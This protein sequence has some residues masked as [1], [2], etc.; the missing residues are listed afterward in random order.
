M[1]NNGLPLEIWR[2]IFQDATS[3]DYSP[4]NDEE[5]R[6]CLR[7]PGALYAD[8]ATLHAYKVKRLGTV[9]SLSLVCRYFNEIAL[10]FFF[11][12]VF[13]S[14]QNTTC[15]FLQLITQ[16]RKRCD[17][18][19]Q[20]ILNVGSNS[21]DHAEQHF[22]DALVSIIERAR[23]LEVFQIKCCSSSP[24]WRGFE[25]SVVDLLPP[26]VRHF[27]WNST[28][29]AYLQSSNDSCLRFFQRAKSNLETIELAGFFPF[30]NIKPGY[31]IKDE[32]VNDCVYPALRKLKVSCS[33]YCDLALLQ[34]WNTTENLVCLDIGT[35][36]TFFDKREASASFFQRLHPHLRCVH[37]GEDS[38]ICAPLAKNI[39]N[40]APKLQV[41]DYFIYGYLSS[42]IWEGSKH[43]NVQELDISLSHGSDLHSLFREGGVH[44]DQRLDLLKSHLQSASSCFSSLK[45]VRF[46]LTVTERLG[47]SEFESWFKDAVCKIFSPDAG[48]KV[49]PVTTFVSP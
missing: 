19:R 1:T 22:R 35:I 40:S 27:R 25:D 13:I 28:G 48:V 33:L 6:T 12:V 3:L 46:R 4:P 32:D 36:W 26:T 31:T 24:E 42:G 18:I 29:L 21:I 2:I 38:N 37:I 10:E 7:P 45:R 11:E 41:V 9:K 44:R 47:G 34:T 8:D 39:L 14:N 23:L 15:K 20:I 5:S 30:P 49:I 17:W 43:E 16:D